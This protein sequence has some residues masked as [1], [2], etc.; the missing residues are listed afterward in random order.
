MMGNGNY[1]NGDGNSYGFGWNTLF[2]TNNQTY[3]TGGGQAI[4][5]LSFPLVAG[6]TYRFRLFMPAQTGAS[7]NN[8]TVNFLGPAASF[9]AI[10][11]LWVVG[12]T[13]V[14]ARTA[15]SFAGALTSS[16]LTVGGMICWVQG[17]AVVTGN[18]NLVPQGT[19]ASAQTWASN[20]GTIMEVLNVASGAAVP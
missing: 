18:G 14:V 3:N 13:G 2:T 20:A 8:A 12:S 19:G 1:L 9:V 5:G 7:S 11:A 15:T 6:N 17:I 4:T 16:G 10:S